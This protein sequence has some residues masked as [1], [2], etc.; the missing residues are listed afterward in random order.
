MRRISNLKKTI[1][2]FSLGVVI[3]FTIS[4][5]VL[6][7]ILTVI[8]T[9]TAVPVKLIWQS[10]VLS[11]LCSLMN[12]IYRSDRLTFAWQSVLGYI[13]TT[14]TIIMCSLIFGWYKF[15]GNRSGKFEW[16]LIMLLLCS[17]SY[18]ITWVIIWR[19]TVARKKE[20]NNKLMEFKNKH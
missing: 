19:I 2:Y 16:V 18:L 11:V 17:S 12:L 4:I 5:I 3:A 1:Q 20:L 9:D 14:G 7:V 8:F 6:S 15:G 10:L 13:L